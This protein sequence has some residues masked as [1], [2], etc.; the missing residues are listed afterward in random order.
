M[1]KH[2]CSGCPGFCLQIAHVCN[3]RCMNLILNGKT[4]QIWCKQLMFT[5]N[6]TKQ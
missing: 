2:A 5:R 1:H 4:N 3:V 6:K